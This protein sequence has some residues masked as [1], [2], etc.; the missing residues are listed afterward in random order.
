MI[1]GF[2]H[3]EN[4]QHATLSF[5]TNLVKFHQVYVSMMSLGILQTAISVLMHDL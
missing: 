5:G 2:L 3:S 1:A 4:Y